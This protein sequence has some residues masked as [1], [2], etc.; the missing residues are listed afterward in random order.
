MLR[1]PVLHLPYCQALRKERN[2]L[3][4]VVMSKHDCI[5]VQTLARSLLSKIWLVFGFGYEWAYEEDLMKSRT[6]CRQI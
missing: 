6:E 5:T 3:N 4:S 1:C 2:R